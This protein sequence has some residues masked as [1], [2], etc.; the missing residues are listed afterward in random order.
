MA[1]TS[2]RV[3]RH[4]DYSQLLHHVQSVGDAPMLPNLAIRH[5]LHRDALDAQMLARWRDAKEFA[6]MCA[7]QRVASRHFVALS[8]HILNNDPEIRHTAPEHGHNGPDS[9]RALR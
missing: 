4:R 7:F 2:L 8:D 5:P 1:S 3:L 9:L 6:L